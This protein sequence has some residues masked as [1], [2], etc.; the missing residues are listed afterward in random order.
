MDSTKLIFLFDGG[1]LA[2][3]TSSNEPKP[4]YDKRVRESPQSLSDYMKDKK[5]CVANEQMKVVLG[6]GF[7]NQLP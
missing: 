3:D 5:L 2:F 4:N 7:G 1:N 6:P